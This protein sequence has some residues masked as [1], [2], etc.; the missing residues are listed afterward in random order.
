MDAF[1][2][3]RP[4]GQSLCIVVPGN[5]HTNRIAAHFIKVGISRGCT[6][7]KLPPQQLAMEREW[8]V[9]ALYLLVEVRQLMV[10]QS[11]TQ[12]A[13]AQVRR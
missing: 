2:Y 12:A 8:R 6:I 1:A 13:K 5:L 4:L 7:E 3:I 9:G 11:R 10:E